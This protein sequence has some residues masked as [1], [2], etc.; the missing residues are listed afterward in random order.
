MAICGG[1]KVSAAPMNC[2]LKHPFGTFLPPSKVFLFHSS[3]HS[4][5]LSIVH[6]QLSFIYILVLSSFQVFH[7]YF[8]WLGEVN[9]QRMFERKLLCKSP[10]PQTQTE[11]LSIKGKTKASGDIHSAFFVRG[12]VLDDYLFVSFI[13]GSLFGDWSTSLLVAGGPL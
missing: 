12:F 3:S 4:A 8:S 9:G 5:L 6:F 7:F 13:W 2:R 11:A 10:F 1:L